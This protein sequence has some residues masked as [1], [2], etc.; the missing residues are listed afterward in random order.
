VNEVVLP[1]G[2]V[3]DDAGAILYHGTGNAV[4]APATA[5]LDDVPDR[6]RHAARPG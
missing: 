6:M 4:T 1:T 2:P 3:L 5:R